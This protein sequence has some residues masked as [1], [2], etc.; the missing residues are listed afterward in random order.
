MNLIEFYQMAR[1]EVIDLGFEADIAY[2][3]SLC[4]DNV[5]E[6]QFLCEYVWVVVNSG[7]KNTV[8]KQIFERWEQQGLEAIGH[9]GKRGA[10]KQV[11]TDIHYYFGG[12]LQATDKLAY[13]KMLP[14]IGDITKYHL[15]RNLGIDCV[16]PDRHLV[17][18]AALLHY[19]TPFN[20]CSEIKQ[21]VPDRLGTIDI[22]LWRWCTL[23]RDY[24][25]LVC[26]L[27]GN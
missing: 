13:L 15:A 11:T 19:D 22:V 20:M 3:E 8:G 21:Q 9:L 26:T 10:I 23:I 14:F 17:R 7:M 18:L 6:K 2:T 12:L 1:Q 4:F 16:K 24:E 25:T 5:T 27:L